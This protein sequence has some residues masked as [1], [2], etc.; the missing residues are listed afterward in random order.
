M[1]IGWFIVPMAVVETI[2]EEGESRWHRQCDM[3]RHNSLIFAD[4]GTW[5]E[6]ECLGDQALVKVRASDATLATIGGTPGF[7]RILSKIDLSEAM[8]DLTAGQ[9]NVITNRLLNMGYI[10]SE[11]DQ[12]MGSSL[13]QWRQK[14]FGDLLD[15][16]ATRRMKP[17]SLNN[18]VLVFST[19]A[20]VP[21][22][23]SNVNKRVK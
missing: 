9:R 7:L 13:A 20:V 8:T 23:P 6:S 12:R 18:G 14:V 5:G 21:E 2:G 16:I 17:L 10:Q 22:R 15:M 11:I 3:N 1:A 4:G 19:E